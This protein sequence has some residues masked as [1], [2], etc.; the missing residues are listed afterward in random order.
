MAHEIN[1]PLAAIVSQGSAGLRWLK[2]ETPNLDE[3]R[4]AFARIVSDGQRAADVIRGLRAL[5]KKSGPQLATLD[6][7]DTIHE[8]LALTQSDVQRQDVVLH[9]GLAVGDRSVM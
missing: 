5:A 2:R 4:D 9:T 8:V 3:A 7:D 6:I 1:Q